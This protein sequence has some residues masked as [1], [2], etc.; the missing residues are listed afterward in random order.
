[1]KR[2]P[3]DDCNPLLTVS[4]PSQ[5]IQF[6]HPLSCLSL[7]IL[8]HI[9]SITTE[10]QHKVSSEMVF[11]QEGS[12]LACRPQ[13]T[14]TATHPQSWTLKHKPLFESWQSPTMVWDWI[15]PKGS[16]V[17]SVVTLE[18][19][20]IFKEHHGRWL[21]A[22]S[23]RGPRSVLLGSRYLLDFLICNKIVPSP[24]HSC[25]DVF[26]NSVFPRRISPVLCSWTSKSMSKVNLSYQVL[27]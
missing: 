27:D 25:H 16:C 2:F 5:H 13:S 24:M 23:C 4:S 15:V 20:G 3:W 22:V 26:C 17:P 1:M 11:S 9:G 12:S 8:P 18:G 6:A 21:G 14:G 7:L 10:S 19:G